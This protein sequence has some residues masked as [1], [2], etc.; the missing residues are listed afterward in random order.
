MLPNTLRLIALQGFTA[1]LLVSCV[2]PQTKA[3]S[4]KSPLKTVADIPLPGPAV[5]SDFQTLDPFSGHLYVAHMN[6]D[7][8]VV[9][10]TAT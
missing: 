5:R 1:V 2:S 8:L 3:N 6:A 4:G 7:H 9:F 10:D